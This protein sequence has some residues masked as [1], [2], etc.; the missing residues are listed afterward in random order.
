MSSLAS[1]QL[2]EWLDWISDSSVDPWPNGKPD[3]SPVDPS[4]E[5]IDPTHSFS[6]VSDEWS[7]DDCSVDEV[8]LSLS[9]SLSLS[10]FPP[11]SVF[12]L[13][14]YFFLFPISISLTHSLPLFILYHTH[15]WSLS[16]PSSFYSLPH[17]LLVFLFLFMKQDLTD[18]V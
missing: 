13:F 3:P 4:S 11:L 14:R 12:V 16:L 18:A 5:R 10:L 17:S 6:E 15:F 1:D 8:V 2:L 9:L 7:E